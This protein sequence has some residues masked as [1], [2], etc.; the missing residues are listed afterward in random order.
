MTV[1]ELVRII[2]GLSQAELR[3]LAQQVPGLREAA[4]REALAEAGVA[5]QVGEPDGTKGVEAAAKP[6][7]GHRLTPEERRAMSRQD[8]AARYKHAV[9]WT[10]HPW[11]VRVAGYRGGRPIILG[12]SIPVRSIAIYHVRHGMNIDAIL[13]GFP[14]LRESQ[15]YDALSYYYDHRDEIEADIE[16]DSVERLIQEYPAGKYELP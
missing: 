14:H 15:V 7:I 10:E 2:E 12:S 13:E 11:V 3:R 9:Q 4:E 5:Y 16:A 1:E 6:P 8:L